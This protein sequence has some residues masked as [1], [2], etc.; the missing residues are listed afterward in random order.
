VD[1]SRYT[2]RV[3]SDACGTILND[4][5]K[6]TV[7]KDLKVKGTT[8][9]VKVGTRVMTPYRGG[10]SHVVPRPRLNLT[11]YHNVFA[12]NSKHRALLTL[13]KP[14]K[15]AKP[16][17]SDEEQQKTPADRRAAMTRA[18]RLKRVFGIDIEIRPACGGAVKVVVSIEEP[19]P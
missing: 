18:Q 6:I 10:L 12:Q 1:E 9:V 16:G 7:I 19:R 15:G 2:G 14:G 4:G 8:L 5:N 17:V 13:A 3:V 11:R